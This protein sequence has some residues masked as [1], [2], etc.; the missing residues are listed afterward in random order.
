[1]ALTE[2]QKAAKARYVKK[3]YD[4]APKVECECG[5]GG[6]MKSVD[7]YGRSRK[8]ITGHNGRKY[9]HGEKQ[10]HKKAWVKRNRQWANDRR[11]RIA[12]QR[13]IKLIQR[14]GGQCDECGL[15]YSGKNGAV[16][17]FHHVDPDTKLFGIGSELSNKSF[18]ELKA[19]ADKCQ[20]LCAN[21]H[22]I[23]HLGEY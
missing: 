7:E 2:A 16:F 6:K 15:E 8:F 18:A 1:M 14:L 17:E 5:C 22:Q 12:R 4:E 11:R 10:P 13:K 20:L 3:K 19:E 21:C 23:G 9:P